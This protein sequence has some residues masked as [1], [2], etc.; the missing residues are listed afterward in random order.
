VCPGVPTRTTGAAHDHF[1]LNSTRWVA[2]TPADDVSPNTVLD[3][4]RDKLVVK[5]SETRS[6]VDHVLI[7][8]LFVVCRPM[9]SKPER[10][11][12]TPNCYPGPNV[13]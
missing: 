9:A 11:E 2:E 4:P 10:R 8:V 13:R 12:L 1:L 6:L 7:V 3:S 5:I